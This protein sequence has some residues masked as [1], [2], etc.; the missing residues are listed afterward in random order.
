V[1]AP[2]PGP[3]RP[4]GP[5]AAAASVVAALVLAAAVVLAVSSGERDLGSGRSPYLSQ[6]LFGFFT[7][8]VAVIVV[9]GAWAW[10]VQV[11]RRPPADDGPPRPRL[12]WWARSLVSI[13]M[14]LVVILVGSVLLSDLDPAEREPLVPT[15]AAP[16]DDSAGGG[17]D[18][19]AGAAGPL[20]FTAGL[21]VAL[22]ATALLA[23]AARRRL[24][25]D[26]P[27][28]AA[29]DPGPVE[30]DPAP[31]AGALRA[32][33]ED[34]EGI[35]DARQAVIAAY[36]RMQADLGSAGLAR[37]PSETEAE[38]LARVLVRLGAGGPAAR[39]L[40][41]LFEEA[42][43]SAHPVDEAMRADAIAAVRRIADQV[44]VA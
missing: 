6:G 21:A 5:A 3:P 39:R 25:G 13:G 29:A 41:G 14:L 36:V 40:T 10:V 38:L 28:D 8:A 35:A 9:I 31:L 32:S 43:Y 22:T 17:V 19:P 23:L 4:L 15:T 42:R 26:D 44:A 12:P 34:L 30:V 2:E 16:L 37:R 18:R 1:T 20:A 33:L 27:E 24:G 11:R 7:G